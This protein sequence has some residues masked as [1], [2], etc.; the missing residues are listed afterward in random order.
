[1]VE[2]VTNSWQRHITYH[3]GLQN[4]TLPI[5]QCVALRILA[6]TNRYR[7]QKF[8]LDFLFNA[9]LIAWELVQSTC[10]HELRMTI[11]F[12]PHSLLKLCSS[13]VLSAIIVYAAR[14][15]KHP[16][17]WCWGRWAAKELPC[18]QSKVREQCRAP[19]PKRRRRSEAAGL[20]DHVVDTP[21][22]LRSASLGSETTKKVVY[23]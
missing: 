11:D 16:F 21:R 1:M 3:I 8:N 14:K 22:K 15:A 10:V 12:C 13:H 5:T 19:T 9:K 7:L 2:N 20:N 4:G 6:I 23:G 18:H 17:S